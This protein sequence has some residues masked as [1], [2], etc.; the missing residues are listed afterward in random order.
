MEQVDPARARVVTLLATRRA[1]LERLLGLDDLGFLEDVLASGETLERRA[2]HLRFGDQARTRREHLPDLLLQRHETLTP[3]MLNWVGD[4]RKNRTQ[5]SGDTLLSRRDDEMAR[6]LVVTRA[7][8]DLADHCVRLCEVR[9]V[10]FAESLF[11]VRFTESLF[12]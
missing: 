5:L 7:V 4:C 6:A 2:H 3:N 1:G 9:V 11:V 10:R 8:T 12:V